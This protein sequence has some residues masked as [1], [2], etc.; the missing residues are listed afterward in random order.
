MFVILLNA[1]PPLV[2][3]TQLRTASPRFHNNASEHIFIISYI[4]GNFS[5][6][7]LFMIVFTSN[8]KITS[9]DIYE[10]LSLGWLLA[11][12]QINWGSFLVEWPDMSSELPWSD[13][14]IGSKF[15]YWIIWTILR[16]LEPRVCR[17]NT[18][19]FTMIAFV[20][21]QL[22]M[23]EASECATRLLYQRTSRTVHTWT[24]WLF[25]A[26]WQCDSLVP[27]SLKLFSHSVH[28]QELSCSPSHAPF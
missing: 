20:S 16:S 26:L 14:M 21:E 13:E 22:F 2:P 8:I 23:D 7:I 3:Y 1:I 9:F 18:L 25:R 6:D 11:H 27:C 5:F 10:L 19:E 12:F 15:S 24:S 4:I 17:Q 28:N